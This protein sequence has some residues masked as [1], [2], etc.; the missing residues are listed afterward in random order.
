TGR[1]PFCAPLAEGALGAAL[2]PANSAD[3]EGAWLSAAAALSLYRLA[4]QRPTHLP[5]AS[6]PRCP[7]DERP[8]CSRAAGA[9]LGRM[10]AGEF[11]AALPEWLA[12]VEAAGRRVPEEYLP[13]LLDFGRT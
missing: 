1:K 8:R 7:P 10:L 6:I 13:A 9:H 3:A 2:P 11:R 4:G 12:A 5:T